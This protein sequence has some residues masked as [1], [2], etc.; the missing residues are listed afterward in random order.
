MRPGSKLWVLS[1]LFLAIA[2]LHAQTLRVAAASDLQFVLPEIAKEYEK[3]TGNKLAITYGASGSLFAQIQNGAPF[4]VFLSA[5]SDLPHRLVMAGFADLGSYRPYGYGSLVLWLPAG[6]PIDPASAGL[7]TLLNPRIQKIAIANPE[8]APYG[9]E[10]VGALKEVGLYDQVKDKL[11]YGEN[12][13]QAAQFV[14]SG[15]A[16]AGLI[17]CSLSKSPRLKD[18][19]GWQFLPLDFLLHQQ[20]AVVLKS[21]PSQKAAAAFMDF[22]RTPAVGL[23][24]EKNCIQPEHETKSDSNR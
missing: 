18:S 4:D 8:H 11:V 9:R 12:V 23:I 3:A 21:S 24:L 6:F 16:Q 13:S 15:N 14:Q 2:P 10:A 5:D 1:C 22:L 20:A 7:R 19:G 17:P